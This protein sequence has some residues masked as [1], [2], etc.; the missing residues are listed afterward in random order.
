MNKSL[1]DKDFSILYDF[2]PLYATKIIKLYRFYFSLFLFFL[3]CRDTIG[4]G[5]PESS[6]MAYPPCF[7]ADEGVGLFYFRRRSQNRG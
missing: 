5:D 6:P 7:L 3:V 2:E 4:E 1:L